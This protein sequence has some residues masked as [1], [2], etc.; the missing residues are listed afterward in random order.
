MPN[1]RIVFL[2]TAEFAVPSLE[3][4]LDHGYDIAAVVTTPDKPR[5]RGQKMHHSPIKAA[6]LKHNLLVLQPVKLKDPDFIEQLKNCQASLQVVV[7]FRILPKVVWAMPELGTVNLH[8]ALLPQYR[9]AAPIN[10]AIINGET[11]TGVTTFLLEQ[12]V[13]T[14]YLLFQDKEPIHSDD[15]AGTLYERLK[16]KGAQLVLKTVQAIAKG[17]YTPTPQPPMDEHLLKKAP[18]IY[19]ENCHIDWHQKAAAIHNFVRGLAPYPA[20]WATLNDRNFKIL[21][22]AIVTE[23]HAPLAP[24]QLASDG[25][26][27]VYVGTA[28][29]PIAIQALQLA[30]KRPMDIATFLRGHQL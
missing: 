22:T 18:K 26:K 14:G 1:L 9:G 2:G 28:T 10:W 24:G 19:K 13:D 5:G 29:A 4:L 30:G 3:I 11:E 17:T 7:A 23:A 6:A 25:K 8:A 15:T 16:Q 20:A 27:Y 12:T 21:K